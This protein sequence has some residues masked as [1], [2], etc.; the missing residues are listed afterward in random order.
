L[1]THFDTWPNKAFDEMP[2]D[3][4]REAHNAEGR[5]LAQEIRRMVEDDIAIDY[6]HIC[7][8]SEA[9]RVRNV[10]REQVIAADTHR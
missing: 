8:Q 2:S 10:I 3:F 5:L 1:A 7:A 6:L 4:Q 9:N